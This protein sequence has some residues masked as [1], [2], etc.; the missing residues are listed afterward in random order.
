MLAYHCN[1]GISPNLQSK[2]LDNIR[3]YAW[4]G[5]VQSIPARTKL[6]SFPNNLVVGVKCWNPDCL[7]LIP[8]AC[9]PLSFHALTA[10][11]R[12]NFGVVG[13]FVADLG[14]VLIVLMLP[15]FFPVPEGYTLALIIG[16]IFISLFGWLFQAT[17]SR[18]LIRLLPLHRSPPAIGRNSRTPCRIKPCSQR[19]EPC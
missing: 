17:L 8:S 3:L 19:N 16:G 6:P 12:G 7:L 13:M 10:H 14:I 9:Y 15:R 5:M 2:H 4:P 18:L 11:R 1:A